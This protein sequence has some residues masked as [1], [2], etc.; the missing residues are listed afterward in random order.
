M[1][2][3]LG[4]VAGCSDDAVAAGEDLADEFDAEAGGAAGYEPD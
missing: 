1:I 2:C 4:G 3:D